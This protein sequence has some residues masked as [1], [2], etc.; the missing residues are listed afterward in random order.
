[1][2]SLSNIKNLSF[3]LIGTCYDWH[4]PVAGALKAHA[5]QTLSVQSTSSSDPRSD[6]FWDEFAYEWRKEFFAYLEALANE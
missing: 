2:Q 5:S 1:M 4:T 3:D 6:A